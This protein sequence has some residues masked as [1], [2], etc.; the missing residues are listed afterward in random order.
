VSNIGFEFDP[1][2]PVGSRIISASV[3]GTPIDSERI[4]VMATRGYMARGKDGYRSLLVQPEGGECEEVVSE[5]NGVLI[6]TI[7]RQYFMSLTV[8]D[9]WAGWAPSMERHWYVFITLG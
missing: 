9:K 5:E 1:A 4:Y 6:S 2:R 8:M 3:G 7:L